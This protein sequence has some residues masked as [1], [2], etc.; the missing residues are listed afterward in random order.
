MIAS[1]SLT[2]PKL[3]LR[4]P[5]KSQNGRPCLHPIVVTRHAEGLQGDESIVAAAL[6]VCFRR[7]VLAAMPGPRPTPRPKSFQQP[8]SLRRGPRLFLGVFRIRILVHRNLLWG[9]P[10]FGKP[11]VDLVDLGRKTHI[12]SGPYQ[13]P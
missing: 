3:T 2:V 8:G 10:V 11:Q 9:P 13:D 1:I 6:P 12:L 7:L 5:W 4:P